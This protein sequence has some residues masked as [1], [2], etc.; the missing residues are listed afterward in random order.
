MDLFF[1]SVDKIISRK[2]LKYF[3]FYNNIIHI[4]GYVQSE[5]CRL[6]VYKSGFAFICTKSTK[7]EFK[8]K[9]SQTKQYWIEWYKLCDFSLSVAKLMPQMH[10]VFKKSACLSKTMNIFSYGILVSCFFF[11]FLKGKDWVKSLNQDRKTINKIWKMWKLYPLGLLKQ[12][13]R[14]IKTKL[15]WGRD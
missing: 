15:L 6:C 2:I 4:Q 14:G 3:S 9:F 11:F 13:K 5:S 12:M 1:P 7:E 8:K 10:T